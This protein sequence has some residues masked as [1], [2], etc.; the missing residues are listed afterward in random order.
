MALSPPRWTTEQLE[1]AAA[2]ATEGFRRQRLAESRKTYL[3]QIDH[4]REDVEELLAAT[5]DLRDIERMRIELVSGDN[6]LEALRY[7]AGPPISADDL[8]VIAGVSLSAGR[9]RRR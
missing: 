8:K 7:L 1:A 2:E 4:Y 6:R 3:A 5:N 9:G